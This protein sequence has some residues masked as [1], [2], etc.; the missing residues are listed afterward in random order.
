MARGILE[1]REGNGIGRSPF[2]KPRVCEVVLL[3][4]FSHL[5]AVCCPIDNSIAF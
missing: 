5:R 1:F 3:S 2:K 4:A